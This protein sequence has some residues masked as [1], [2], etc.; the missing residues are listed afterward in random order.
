MDFEQELNRLADLYTSR[1]YQVTVRPRPEDLPPF[2]KDFQVDLVARR[3]AEGVL[4]SAKKNRLEMEADK[5]MPRYA[6][7][8]SAQPGWRYDFA[9]LEPEQPGAREVRGAQEL[10]D[11]EVDNALGDA[12]QLVRSG[13]IRPAL[14]T[15]WAALEAAMRRRLRA[16]GE[17]AGWGTSPRQMLNELYSAGDLSVTDFPRLEQVLRSRNEIVHGFASPNVDAGSIQFLI[18]T[19]RCLLQQS[20][21]ETR[22]A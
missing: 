18:E 7:V 8:T 12:E 3:A 20:R 10:L 21:L 14:L 6:E 1:G 2:A 13:F 16:S 22:T 19:A 5:N 4:V 17:V 11:E 9:I 15:A